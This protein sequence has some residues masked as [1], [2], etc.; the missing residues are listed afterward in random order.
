[1]SKQPN[2][3]PG[4]TPPGPSVKVRRGDYRT[5]V[6]ILKGRKLRRIDDAETGRRHKSVPIHRGRHGAAEELLA[7][8]HGSSRR[9]FANLV[10][11]ALATV[12]RRVIMAGDRPN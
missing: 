2:G 9:M 6:E 1:M 12:Q 3:T 10:R 5:L 4:K 11:A 7:Y 8:G